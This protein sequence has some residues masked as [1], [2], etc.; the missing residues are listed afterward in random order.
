MVTNHA[1]GAGRRAT[2]PATLGLFLLILA[3][4]L[5]GLAPQSARAATFNPHTSH[6]LYRDGFVH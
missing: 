2:R 4:I 6:E 1:H 5:V 3:G